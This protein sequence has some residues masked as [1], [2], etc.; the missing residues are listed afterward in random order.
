M[1]IGDILSKNVFSALTVIIRYYVLRHCSPDPNL[2]AAPTLP[3]IRER[4]PSGIINA[5]GATSIA[6][7]FT[8]AQQMAVDKAVFDEAR[9]EHKSQFVL[10]QVEVSLNQA[11]TLMCTVGGEP[12]SNAQLQKVSAA[13][14]LKLPPAR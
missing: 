13:T 1:V 12:S 4:R 8:P 2:P 14:R 3:S 9:P 11:C 10:A 7:A 5:E 6:M